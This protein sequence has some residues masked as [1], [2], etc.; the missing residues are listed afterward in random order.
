MQL[1]DLGDGARDLR[2]LERVRQ[3]SA[4]VIAGG[5]EKHLSLVL[6]AAK[7]LAMDDAVA[8]ALKCR[9]DVVFLFGA[10]PARASPRFS[11]PAAQGPR[12]RAPRAAHEA[13]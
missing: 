4:V 3:S 7:R 9:P 10:K 11:P 2:H 1:Q 13:S 8:V 12:A 6:E 5:G